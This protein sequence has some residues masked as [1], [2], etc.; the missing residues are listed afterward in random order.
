MNERMNASDFQVVKPNGNGRNA[1]WREMVDGNLH[2]IETIN[3][4]RRHHRTLI[5]IEID[6]F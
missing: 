5:R 3:L 2:I 4:H 6:S 1:V